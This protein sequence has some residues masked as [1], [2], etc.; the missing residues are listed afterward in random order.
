MYKR[1]IINQPNVGIIGVGVV[2]KRPI[3]I[4]TDEG[5]TIGIKSMMI[6]SLGFDHRLVDGAGGSQF[7]EIVRKNIES[8]NLENLF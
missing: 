5:D 1:Q 8:M 3:V 6:L 4:E 7:I 2:K